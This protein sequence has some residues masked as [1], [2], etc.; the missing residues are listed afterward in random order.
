MLPR[1]RPWASCARSPR[2]RTNATPTMDSSTPSSCWRDTG[3]LKNSRPMASIHSG[4]LEPTS[5]TFSGDEVCSARY[6]KAL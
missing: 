3:A 1:R 5:V 4:M 6:C 2:A